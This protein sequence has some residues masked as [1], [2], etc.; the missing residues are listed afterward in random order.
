MHDDSEAPGHY[1]LRVWTEEPTWSA[2]AFQMLV[3][4]RFH[5]RYRWD[6]SRNRCEFVI[7]AIGR[8]PDGYRVYERRGT[9]TPKRS[10]ASDLLVR[11][12]ALR[13]LDG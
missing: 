11:D 8:G 9:L 6:N 10:E 13:E 12:A 5:Y 3:P 4:H 2:L 1:R 7:Q